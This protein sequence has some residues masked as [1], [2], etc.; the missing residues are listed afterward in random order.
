ML[1]RNFQP[2]SNVKYFLIL[3]NVQRH[4][5]NSKCIPQFENTNTQPKRGYFN[6]LKSVGKP[7]VPSG[8]SETPLALGLTV[9]FLVTTKHLCF[10]ALHVIFQNMFKSLTKLSIFPKGGNV[11]RSRSHVCFS[12]SL[13]KPK[14]MHN[15]H[16]FTSCFWPKNG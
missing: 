8:L 3:T 5:C 10:Q 6:L 15:S 4:S 7:F 14:L 2:R 9:T 1:S 11:Q 16:V 12:S 13:S